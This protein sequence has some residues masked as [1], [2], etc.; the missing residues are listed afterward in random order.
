ME[1][2]HQGKLIGSTHDSLSGRGTY[3]YLKGIYSSQKG[4]LQISKNSN[5]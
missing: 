4:M 5:G 2:V 1:I 3:V